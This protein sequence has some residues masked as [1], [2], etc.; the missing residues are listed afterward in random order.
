M[1]RPGLPFQTL[2]AE[3]RAQLSVI[4]DKIL[5]R[6]NEMPSASDI[7]LAN[8]PLDKVL[9]SR[10]DLVQPLIRTLSSLGSS[11]DEAD[12]HLMQS[13][14]PQVFETLFQVIAG[15]Y[16]MDARVRR[17]LGYD[18]QR[19]LSLPRAGFGAEELLMEMMETP[20]RYRSC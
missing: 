8:A 18:G 17:L 1:E 10:P 19:A 14:A 20:P 13:N 15:A 9:R 7:D 16:Y 11:I 12:L 3:H 2:D 6:T 4:A 5:P